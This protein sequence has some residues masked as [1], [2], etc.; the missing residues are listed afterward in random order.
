M[1]ASHTS[2]FK[3]PV[4]G[5]IFD[6]GATIDS[7]GMHWAE[8]IWQGYQSAAMPVTKENFRRAYVHAERALA[9]HPYIRPEHN[10][11]Q[12]LQIKIEI[13][14]EFLRNEQLAEG[15]IPEYAAG[16]IAAFCYGFAMGSIEKARPVLQSLSEKYRFVLVSNFYGNIGS[17]LEDF[18]LKSFFPNI[19]ESAVVGVRKP[20]PRIFELGVEQLGF[21]P[22]EIVVIGD[23]YSKDIVPASSLGCNTIWI[24]GIGW[25]EKEELINHPFTIT[26]FAD[27][28]T[29]LK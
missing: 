28:L 26:D 27:L 7:N 1:T 14:L 17:V 19:I 10:F 9:T 16:Q 24:K 25:D 4:K 21:R 8:V 29:L 6:Y 23:S 22:E 3:A 5:L 2:L 15:D 18:N 13:Q 12:L 11:R 20:D